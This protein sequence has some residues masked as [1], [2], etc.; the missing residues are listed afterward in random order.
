MCFDFISPFTGWRTKNNENIIDLV[1]I[2]II[3]VE[4]QRLLLSSQVITCIWSK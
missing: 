4:N 1:S 2:T 3:I